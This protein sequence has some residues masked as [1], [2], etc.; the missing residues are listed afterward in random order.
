MYELYLKKSDDLTLRE[1]SA[2]SAP[3]GNEVKVKAIYGGICGSDLRVYKGKMSHAAY[4]L[5][6]GH[7]IVGTVIEAG[8]DSPHQVGTK[9]V[10]FPNT[11]CGKCEFCLKGK[12]NI[13][14]HKES[15]GVNIDGVFAQE[16]VID[17]KYAVPVPAEITNERA[18]LI[19]PFA[20]TVH[21]LKRAEITKETSVAII[22]CGTEGLLSVVIA[23]HL[24]ADVTVIDLNPL[25]LDI[26]KKFGN[27]K[28]A[29]PQEIKDG[30]F[31]VVIEAAGASKSIEQAMQLVKPG[32]DLIGLGITCDPVNYPAIY[33]VRSQITIH[34]SIIY[35]LKDFAEA[36]EYLKDPNFNVAPVL[37]KIFPYAEYQ[38]AYDTA[39][40]GNFAKIALNFS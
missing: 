27:V 18:V 12:T 8:S 37:S 36:I 35:T 10:I 1:V 30:T 14:Q 16:I 26:A 3:Q 38:Q 21:A 13:C 28:T 15:L 31:D 5:R 32:G 34:G 33:V 2:L 4:P 39:L 17:S 40:T 7:E 25:K 11:F 22:G 6:P 23:K 19:E 9:V 20:V 24:G 29:Q